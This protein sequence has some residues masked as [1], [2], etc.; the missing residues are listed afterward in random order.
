MSWQ[1]TYRDRLGTAEEAVSIVED[2]D[3]VAV[4]L[5]EQPMALMKAL[6]ER[7]GEVR[8][9]TLCVSV[10]QFDVGPFLDAGW[11]VEIENFIGPYGRPYENEGI[12]PYSPLAFSL[13]FKATDE[14][15]DEAKPIDVALA[16]VSR[17]NG[18]GQITFGPQ[19]WHKRGFA[20]RARKVAVEVNPALIRTYGDGFM[21]AERI[22]RMVEV[23]P[24]SQS[25]ESLL[26]AV[27]DLP[28]ERRAALED[29]IARVNP[30][31]LSL[32]S[33]QLATIDL[34]RLRAQLGI[35]EP[36]AESKAIA[37]NV[38]PLIADGSTIQIGVG[39]PSSYLPRL[40]VFDDKADPRP[41]LRAD[42]AGGSPSWWARAS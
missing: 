39:T 34:G 30:N 41:A 23:E 32:L 25:R 37:E 22:D 20:M 24:S 2:G 4:P 27:A 1:D 5:S 3:R 13:T 11:N 14:R 21:P 19:S 33:A 36:S 10:P 29:V 28:N 8:G 18:H 15:P 12:A 40:G 17:P 42:G 38:K 7:A 26:R 9:A 16:T 31:R 6:A 35:D